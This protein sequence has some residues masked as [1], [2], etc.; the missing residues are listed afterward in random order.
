VAG[1]IATEFGE[2]I[3][4]NYLEINGNKLTGT[5]A[6]IQL[7]SLDLASVDLL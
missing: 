5:D 7:C 6:L 4:L 1:P 3:N 2:L